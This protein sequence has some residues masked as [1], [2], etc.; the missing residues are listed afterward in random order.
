MRNITNSAMCTGRAQLCSPFSWCSHGYDLP[1][2]WWQDPLAR[3]LCGIRADLSNYCLLPWRLWVIVSSSSSMIHPSKV[4]VSRRFRISFLSP[5]SMFVAWAHRRKH[6]KRNHC[7][8][9]QSSIRTFCDQQVPEHPFQALNGQSPDSEVAPL[10][11][12]TIAFF[13]GSF[14]NTY[15]ASTY[16]PRAS[17][18]LPPSVGC[19]A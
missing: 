3:C 9:Y 14:E 5:F 1:L 19:E 16:A 11:S 6:A 15:N 12:R 18:A 10:L 7:L 4:L 17:G 8:P 2:H 13:Q